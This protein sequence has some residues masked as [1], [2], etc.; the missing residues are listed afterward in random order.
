MGWRIGR[1]QPQSLRAGYGRPPGRY[2]LARIRAGYDRA[3]GTV[4]AR[5][6]VHFEPDDMRTIY[7]WGWAT[8]AVVAVALF[9]LAGRLAVTWLFVAHISPAPGLVAAFNLGVS[10]GLGLLGLVVTRLSIRRWLA[11]RRR[12]RPA[13]N[14]SDSGLPRDAAAP[15]TP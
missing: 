5:S 1:Y 13:A 2:L 14:D 12:Q 15:V 8:L 9:G 11:K 3:K 4:V 7:T 10:A 6:P